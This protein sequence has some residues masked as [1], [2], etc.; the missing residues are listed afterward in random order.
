MIGIRIGPVEM[1]IVIWL[2][3]IFDENR[4]LKLLSVSSYLIDRLM[5][6]LLISKISEQLF[7]EQVEYLE[8]ASVCF[9]QSVGEMFVMLGE[10]SC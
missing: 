3:F 8:N 7:I 9:K 2:L 10:K 1:I 4:H 6:L 5:I